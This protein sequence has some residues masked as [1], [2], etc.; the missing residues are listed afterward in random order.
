MKSFQ[1]LLEQNSKVFLL[2]CKVRIVTPFE[3]NRVL[4][5]E[6]K[7]PPTQI[8]AENFIGA[9]MTKQ[10]GDTSNP[11]IDEW[12]DCLHVI[13]LL[14]YSMTAVSPFLVHQLGTDAKLFDIQ[15]YCQ[16]C[17]QSMSYPL[18]ESSDD[19][20]ICKRNLKLDDTHIWQFNYMSHQL[21]TLL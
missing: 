13:Q 11:Q 19:E 20:H 18:L 21:N 15:M 14:Y 2:I 6:R 16:N 9:N 5:R 7:R 4:S 3:T 8:S 12:C 10:I 17:R 1:W